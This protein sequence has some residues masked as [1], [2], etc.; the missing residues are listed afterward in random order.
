MFVFFL[1]AIHNGRL[2]YLGDGS[3]EKPNIYCYYFRNFIVK[4]GHKR[5]GDLRIAIFAEDPLYMA[6]YDVD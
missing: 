5:E 1:G 2:S 3:L 6:P 4:S